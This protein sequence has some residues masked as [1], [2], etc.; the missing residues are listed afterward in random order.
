MVNCYYINIKIN[1]NSW[2]TNV[3][4]MHLLYTENAPSYQ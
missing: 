2:N 4:G 3:E 1:N